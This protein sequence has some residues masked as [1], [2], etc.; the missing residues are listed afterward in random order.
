MSEKKHYRKRKI[1]DVGKIPKPV[2]YDVKASMIEL[3]RMFDLLR[4]K[5]EN[6]IEIANKDGRL[7][8]SMNGI[9]QQFNKLH[10]GIEKL[11]V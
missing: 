6:H 2:N 3:V 11:N 4:I 7:S 1:I 9:H 8:T 5:F 10:N